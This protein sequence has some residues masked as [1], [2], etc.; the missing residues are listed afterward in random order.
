MSEARSITNLMGNTVATVVIAKSEKEIDV[1]TYHTIV[2]GK[3]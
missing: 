2:E 1:A 3:L